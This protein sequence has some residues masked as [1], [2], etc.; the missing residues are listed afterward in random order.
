MTA[1]SFCGRYHQSTP[2]AVGVGCSVE[3]S[4]LQLFFGGSIANRAAVVRQASGRGV[5]VR[6]DS[7]EA[8]VAAAFAAWQE[9]LP[10]YVLGEFSAVIC[11]PATGRVVLCGDS[12]GLYPL[13]YMAD[14][15]QIAFA[16]YLDDLLPM[17]SVPPLDEEYI[18]DFL[19]TGEHTGART[20]FASIHRLLPGEVLSWQR[21]VLTRSRPW[22]WR[23]IP[24][25]RVATLDETAEALL[26]LVRDG[27]HGAL[28]ARG[29]VWCELSGGL[30]SST[31]ACVARK[32]R[33]S[34]IEALTMVYPRTPDA[35]EQAWVREVIR[36]YPMTWHRLDAESALPFVSLPDRAP[37]EPHEGV[38]VDGL[39]ESYRDLAATNGVTTIL[40]G[41]G[42]DA[43][44]VGEGAEPLY[45]GEYL[46]QGRF[47]EVWRLSGEWADRS[48][49]RRS[50]AYWLRRHAIGPA[51]SYCRGASPLRR[52]DAEL[53]VWFDPVYVRAVGLA[54]RRQRLRAD[55]PSM[56]PGAASY[57][58]SIAA[59]CQAV[60]SGYRSRKEPFGFR[61]PLLD[62]PL[63]EFMAGIP[64]EL[65]LQPD[66]HRL[67]QRRALRGV[68]PERIRVREDKSGPSQTYFDGLKHGPAWLDPSITRPLVVDRGYVEPRAWSAAI[69]KARFGVVS[70]LRDFVTTAAL[71]AW[72][73]QLETLR[74][75]AAAGGPLQATG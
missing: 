60:R 8:L 45:W 11:D 41:Q 71:E 16:Q 24:P 20:P 6:D 73:Q 33:M 49:A 57:A 27:V 54:R 26:P 68:L 30:D 56:K 52:D 38:L 40:S 18:A 22:R 3:P 70:S 66:A 61:F 19:A 13:F 43:V 4:G 63:V 59:S 29:K 35:D 67:V 28:P 9:Q 50:R 74:R 36:A 48:R 44:F 46:L 23:D 42:G 62:R 55:V 15:E 31:I 65:K 72:L 14:T 12:L 34:D 47:R 21:G 32:W 2:T 17:A 10:L 69:Q 58:A 64:W 75:Q 37:A 1:A 53:P 39:L 51:W 25:K 7:D 5:S